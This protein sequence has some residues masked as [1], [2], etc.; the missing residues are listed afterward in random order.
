MP[1]HRR[2]SSTGTSGL[3]A[4]HDLPVGA[5]KL[6]PDAILRNNNEWATGYA[7]SNPGVF[8][9]LAQG[10]KPKYLIIGCSDS[11][12]SVSNMMGTEPGQV[13]A[14]RNIANMVV[15]SDLNMMSVM[16]Y[17]IE[18]L[19]VEHVIVCGHYGCGGVKAAMGNQ[20]LGFLDSWLSEIKKVRNK[21]E[22]K[23]F[24]KYAVE[25]KRFEK[26]CEANVAEQVHNVV[27]NPILQAAWARGQD[28]TVHGWIYN[29]QNGR[30]TDLD[31]S[32]NALK[33]V[34]P[35][36]KLTFP[37][38]V[39][40]GDEPIDTL[41]DILEKN[42]DWAAAQDPAFLRSLVPS[43]KPTYLWLG[44]S[45]SRVPP[46]KVLGVG[47]GEVFV[48]RDIANVVH[49][50]DVS[51]M[52]VLEYAVH[53]LKVKHVVVCGHYGCGGVK[54]AMGDHPHGLIDHWLKSIRDVIDKNQEAISRLPEE[55]KFDKVCELNTASQ[56]LNVA[57]SFVIQRA[58]AAGLDVTVH[59]WIFR[60]GT[61]TINNLKL[62]FS[63]P[64][65]LSRIFLLPK[66]PS[67]VPPFKKG[68]VNPETEV[69]ARIATS[70]APERSKAVGDGPL[71]AIQSALFFGLGIV[72]AV[73]IMQV[74][75]S[76]KEPAAEEPKGWFG[77]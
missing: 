15:N 67:D 66:E 9:R 5:C 1:S 41:E 3:P 76:E 71:Q 16:Q 6:E 44:C 19:K 17:A 72:G 23:I 31:V 70:Q 73:A 35:V 25:K 48:H 33:F 12:V 74:K 63:K 8:D 29:I 56:A 11:R 68:M 14:T 27:N 21:H 58:W 60:L 22:K 69:I 57:H 36:H 30:L 18:Y 39:S 37:N 65:D 45:D 4:V 24:S 77:R 26:M 34:S 52:S 38:A 2:N 53:H 59:S 10:Q 7:R 55:E 51:S 42:E 62:S 46:N 49:A 64:A 13:F 32:A 28:I 47:P 40:K 20:S 61:G 54:A 43:Q 50:S 75:G